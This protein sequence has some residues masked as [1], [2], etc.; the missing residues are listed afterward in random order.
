MD[1]VYFAILPRSCYTYWLSLVYINDKASCV[2]GGATEIMQMGILIIVIHTNTHTH[3]ISFDYICT[4]DWALSSYFYAK[5]LRSVY[6]E[7]AK[8]W[9]AVRGFILQRFINAP[10]LRVVC[11]RIR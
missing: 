9:K 11:L 4:A 6:T 1:V 7:R 5:S 2:G 3:I 8:Q 10:W